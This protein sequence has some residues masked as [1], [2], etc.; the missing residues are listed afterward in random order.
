[1]AKSKAVE[2][3]QKSKFTIKDG[4]L[5]QADILRELELASEKC[6]PVILYGPPGTGK[7]RFLNLFS[8]FLKT[9]GKL[10]KCQTVQF[11]KK[12]SYEDFIEGFSPSLSGFQNRDGVFKLFCKNPSDA[13]LV[14][15]FVI[16]E[17]NR[18]DLATTF[19]ETLFAI[20]DRKARTVK[21]SHFGDEFTIPENLMIVGT[22]N[23]ADRNISQFDFAIRRRFRFIPVFPSE[24]ALK[25]WL[26]PIGFNHKEFTVDDYVTF[27]SKINERVRRNPLLGSHMQLG[28]S[29]FVPS[30]SSSPISAEELAA[31]FSEVIIPQ[32]EAYF[33]F[34]NRRE[35]SLIFNPLITES[36][37]YNRRIGS[38]LFGA[39]VRETANEK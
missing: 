15:L 9:K 25:E 13:K 35:L 21:T 31:N 28:Q 10:G 24:S 34:G 23:T 32:V 19:G 17:I 3:D 6:I 18:A 27:F 7:T 26:S 20:E 4:L 8:S 1:M 39:F 16:D 36:Y 5:N 30:G 29:L 33:G 22:M 2:F 12:F 14:D 37:L 11:H 38:E